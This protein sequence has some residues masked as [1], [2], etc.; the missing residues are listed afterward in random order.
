MQK[1]LLT[2]FWRGSVTSGAH[3]IGGTI[4]K[5]KQLP[6]TLALIGF[7]ASILMC[8]LAGTSNELLYY[9]GGI[10]SFVYLFAFA[11]SSLTASNEPISTLCGILMTVSGIA[12][13]AFIVM[14]FLCFIGVLG[15]VFWFIT[16]AIGIMVFGMMATAVVVK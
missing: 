8:C 16:F 4:M 2:I 14:S 9:M 5:Q 1:K 6:T 12:L 10:L 13:L 11:Y 7:F 15:V 3:C